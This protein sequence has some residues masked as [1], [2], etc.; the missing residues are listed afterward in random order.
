MPCMNAGGSA[1]GTATVTINPA[2]TT[3]AVT[4]FTYSGLSA[5]ASAAHIHFGATGSNGP[6]VLPFGNVASPI[7]Q[8][9]TAGD[10]I[11][12]ATGPQTFAAFVTEMKAGHSYLNIH[13]STT[14]P[15]GEIRGQIQ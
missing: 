7:N 11:V 1:T 9:F 2:G 14:C 3:I 4:D 12:P 8:T 10:Y 6:V 13:T 15:D 5:A